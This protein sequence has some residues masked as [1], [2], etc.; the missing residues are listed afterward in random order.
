MEIDQKNHSKLIRGLFVGSVLGAA[1]GFLLAPKSGKE[2]RVGIK[3]KT[4][5][6]L[7]ETKQLYSNGCTRFENACASIAGR[8]EGASL[9]TI[10]SPEE[11][12]VDA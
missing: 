11:I 1:A 10:E 6:V 5:K 9:G 3:E 7:E 2:L 4:N 12:V 8:R